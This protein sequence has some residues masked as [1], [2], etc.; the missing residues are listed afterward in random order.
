MVRSCASH[1]AKPDV[2]AYGDGVTAKM[3]RRFDRPIT[4]GERIGPRSTIWRPARSSTG[5]SPSRSK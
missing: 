1:V 4:R 5:V 2:P 3:N